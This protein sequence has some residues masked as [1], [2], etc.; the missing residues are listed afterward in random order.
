MVHA[1]ERSREQK[2][3][4]AKSCL[5]TLAVRSFER[6]RVR[7]YVVVGPRGT[8]LA[9]DTQ[10]DAVVRRPELAVV[11][12]AGGPRLASLEERFDC[13]LRLR[14]PRLQGDCCGA[15]VVE[16][17]AVLLDAHRARADASLDL[18]GHTRCFGDGSSKVDKGVRLPLSLSRCTP[19]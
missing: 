5:D 3:S 11:A 16:F 6:T 18:G 12:L 4:L 14:H 1:D 2:S 7:A 17:G 13:L 10:E 15:A 9:E 19:F 8:R